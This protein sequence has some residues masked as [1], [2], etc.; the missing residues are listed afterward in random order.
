MLLAHGGVDEAAERQDHLLDY[1]AFLELEAVAVDPAAELGPDPVVIPFRNV[2]LR[3]ALEVHPLDG[4]GALADEGETVVRVGVDQLVRAARRFGQDA[5]QREGVLGEV[6]LAVRFR[7]LEPAV[8]A[9]AVGAHQE[10]RLDLELGAVGIGEPDLRLP[11][12]SSRSYNDCLQR[13]C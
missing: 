2:F 9:G 10:V 12:E 3:I 11:T 6:P 5:E 8:A 1:R 4:L 7:D 13:L